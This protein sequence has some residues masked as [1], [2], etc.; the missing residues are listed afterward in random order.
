MCT[1]IVRHYV[2][3]IDKKVIKQNYKFQK[4]NFTLKC[5]F[6]EKISLKI[7]E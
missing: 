5:N 6:K 3:H 4:N 2:E 1:R 7:E